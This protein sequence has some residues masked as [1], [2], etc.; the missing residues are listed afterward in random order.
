MG[1]NDLPPKARARLR[2][3]GN[4]YAFVD[5]EDSVTTGAS[6][7]Q[8]APTVLGREGGRIHENQQDLFACPQPIPQP[9]RQSP[10]IPSGNPYARIDQT[11]SEA[12]DGIARAQAG[13]REPRV[14]KLEFRKRCTEIFRQY[15]PDLEGGG[16]RGYMRDFIARNESSPSRVRYSLLQ[17]LAK[18]DLSDLAGATPL[19]NREDEVLSELKL[20]EIERSVGEDE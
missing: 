6:T 11:Q 9:I 19:F 8:R 17:R 13:V 1:A 14:T 18:Y 5:L 10:A 3:G 2:L 12:A 4:P 7:R 15:I 16:L 20:K